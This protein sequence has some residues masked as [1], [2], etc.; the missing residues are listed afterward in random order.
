MT[1]SLLPRPPLPSRDGNRLSVSSPRHGP[2]SP[3]RA[4]EVP[5]TPGRF[6]HSHKWVGR[7]S[8]LT[9]SDSSSVWYATDEQRFRRKGMQSISREDIIRT[10][11]QPLAGSRCKSGSLSAMSMR[12][13]DGE[14]TFQTPLLYEKHSRQ[15]ARFDR[16]RSNERRI[17]ATYEREEQRKED[18]RDKRRVNYAA[19]RSRFFDK[20]KTVQDVMYYN[21]SWRDNADCNNL[22]Q[23][24]T[25]PTG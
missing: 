22:T 1:K 13:I 5:R 17:I 18:M 10:E 15:F 6:D 7:G 14:P 2:G 21:D 4:F 16:S 11:H 23:N 8:L 12:R 3:R 24:I 9:S 20:L 25:R 19:Q